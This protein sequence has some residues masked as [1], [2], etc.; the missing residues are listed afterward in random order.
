MKAVLRILHLED[1]PQDAE[2]VRSLL[3]GEGLVPDV[4]RVDTREGFRAAL[5]HGQF[6]LIVS[7][8]TLPTFDGKSALAMARELAPE[9]PFI[10]VSGTMGEDAAITTLRNGATDYVLKHRIERFIPAVRRTLREIDDRK[11]RKHAEDQMR[12]SEEMFRVIAENATDLIAVLDL[13]GR[14]LYNSPSYESILGDPLALR[15]TDSFREIHPDDR[16]NIKELFQRTVATGIGERAEFRFI[17]KDGQIRFIESQGNL[18]RDEAGRPEKIVVVSRDVSERKIAEKELELQTT[19]LRQLFENSPTGIV[20]LDPSDRVMNTNAAF[21]QIFQFRLE[22]IR[23]KV[24]DEFITP[25]DRAQESR[26]LHERS[27]AGGVVQSETVRHRKDGTPVDL[28]VT[29]CPI[30]I[31]GKRVGVYNLFVDMTEQKKL[32]DDLRQAQKMESIGTLAAGIAHDFNNILGIIMGHFTLVKKKVGERADIASNSEAIMTAVDRGAA[33]VR[34]IMTY[35]RKTGSLFEPVI[36]DDI[37]LELVS[38]F[39]ET[40]PKTIRFALELEQPPCTI[41]ADRTQM[42]QA[43]LNLCVNARDAMPAGGRITIGTQRVRSENVK[44]AAAVGSASAYLCIRVSDTGSGIDE[45]TRTHIFEPFFTTKERDKGTGLGLSVV[46]GIVKAH[47]GL[48]EVQS[49]MGIGTTFLLYLPVPDS[50]SMPFDVQGTERH[51]VG[52][53]IATVLIVEDEDPMRELLE[54]IFESGGYR[55]LS[56]RDGVEAIR[57]FQ[58]HSAEITVVLS[59]FG[60]PGLD[61]MTMFLKMRQ[62][63]RNVRVVFTSGY[64]DSD[65]K[66]E[67]FS[68]G[69][70]EIISKPFDP[71]RVMDRVGEILKGG[72]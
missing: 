7:D 66:H 6:D 32:E 69:V 70:A 10:F 19:Y 20:L 57:I 13:E 14:R 51:T 27:L 36:V 49:Q 8:F 54:G 1:D 56:A 25:A 65:Q 61:G 17:R 22:E 55:V 63:N 47:G 34:Q 68:L 15:G 16:E 38:M 18:V 3:E 53:G 26:T 12:A 39:E 42:H 29:G 11:T 71:N 21:Q 60:L 2:L 41:P 62:V 64:L 46:Y 24:L 50:E 72:R 37:I 30:E 4:V 59:D 52:S 44:N 9:T 35:A 5:S 45:V 33:L 48:I 23:G 28:I 40:F 31:G 67:L 43:L 58:A